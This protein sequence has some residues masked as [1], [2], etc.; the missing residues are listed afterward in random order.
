M[1]V[2]RR[3]RATPPGPDIAEEFTAGNWEFTPGVAEVF[4]AH[5]RASVPYYDTIQDL[6]AEATDWILPAGGLFVDLGAATGTTAGRILARHPERSYQAVLYDDQPAM[7]DKAR[8]RLDSYG[9]QVSYRVQRIQDPPFTHEAADLTLSLFTLQFLR[10]EDR[11]AALRMARASSRETG[12]LIVAEKLRCCDAR[13]AEIANDVSHDVKQAQGI[14][15]TAIRA[16]A[17]AL[18]GV[19]LPYPYTDLI[20]AIQTAGWHSPEVLFRWHNWA[21]VGAFATPLTPPS[22]R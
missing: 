10:Y 13:W 1:G 6:I 19:L 9:D 11:I 18:R 20:R 5:V 3:L 7:L 12:A 21:V 14:S 17:R 8:Q 15:D 4:D 22:F 16:K 2:P